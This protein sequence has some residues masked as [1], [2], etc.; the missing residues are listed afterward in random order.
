MSSTCL[1]LA[2]SVVPAGLLL[3][4]LLACLSERLCPS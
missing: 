2:L 4:F 3:G 1:P